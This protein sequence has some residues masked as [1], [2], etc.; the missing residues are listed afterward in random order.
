MQGGVGAYTQRLAEALSALGCE[1]HLLSS[2]G[3]HSPDVYLP[4]T[5]TPDWGFGVLGR[6]ARW[7]Q[8]EKFDLVNL[9]Y[10]TAAFSMS[11]Y[12]HFLPQAVKHVPFVTTFHDLRFPYLF[13][14]AGA[15][16][17]A[18]VRRLANGSTGVIAT[19]HEDMAALNT[20]P[21][22]VMIPIGSNLKPQASSGTSRSAGQA[23]TIAYFG[24]RNQSKGLTTL[25][26]SVAQLHANGLPARLRLIGG[27]TGSSDPTNAQYNQTLQAQIDQ[28]GLRPFVEESGYV[29]D[30]AV[31]ALL[32]S[33]DVIALP[34]LDGASYRRGSLMAALQA[35]AAI[36]TTHPALPISAFH[37]G[38][39][40]LFV[41]PDDPAALAGALRQLHDQPTLAHKLRQG[42]LSLSETFDWASI[43][44]ST[45]QFYQ[46]L[47]DRK[48]SS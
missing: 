41:P 12:I 4:L 21:H 34:F 5:H 22:A 23:F 44:R 1:L 42:A 48:A 32:N 40:M 18:I 43:A 6:A 47:T 30:T 46:T 11:P 35:G 20:H 13:P 26:E 19:N 28:A 33:S 9:Q 16:R 31:A 29:D 37:D 38:E 25:V 39:N 7:A 3:T 10:Q 2:P 45:L 14:K 15:L 17:P 36:V 24:F 27:L 8:A